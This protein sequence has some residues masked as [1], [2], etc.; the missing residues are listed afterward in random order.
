MEPGKRIDELMHAVLDGESSSSQQAELERALAADPRLRE[1]F[2]ALKSLFGL[3]ERLPSADPP[4]GLRESSIGQFD[5]IR[6]NVETARQLSGRSRV[7]IAPANRVEQRNLPVLQ[8]VFQSFKSMMG[9]AMND[10]PSFIGTTKGKVITAAGTAVVI[11]GIVFFGASNHSA[12]SDKEAAGT[13]VSAERYRAAQPAAD[14]VPG[15]GTAAT[16]DAGVNAATDKEAA[17]SADRLLRDSADSRIRDSADM[18][19]R[20]SAD[21]IRLRDSADIRARDSADATRVRDS[22]DIRARDSA[23]ATRLRDSADMRLRDSADIRVRDAADKQA[24]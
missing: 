4:A 13:I 23:D 6:K 20:D 17:N 10:Q 11:A 9:F 16:P 12:N 21:A 5:V 22:A 2:D 3:M 19:V 15:G 1:K 8:G 7:D 24:Q 18:R 14:D